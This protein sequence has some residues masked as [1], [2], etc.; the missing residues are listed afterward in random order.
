[1]NLEKGLTGLCNL[2]N[3]CF[4][5]TILQILSHSELLNNFLDTNYQSRLNNNNEAILLVE[6]DNL[7]KL[8]WKKNCIISPERFLKVIQNLAMKKQLL[9]FTDYSQNDVTEFIHFL[10]E[11]FH[12]GIT[13]EVNIKIE[14]ECKNE[15]DKIALLCYSTIKQMYEKDYSMIYK[16]FHGIFY[17]QLSNLETKDII[18]NIPEPFFILNLPI[19]EQKTVD[20]LDCFNLFTEEEYLID[21]NAYFNEKTN[22]KENISKKIFFWSLPD[23]LVIDLKRYN[24]FSRKNQKLVSFP[25]ENLD[26]SEYVV[27]YNKNSY[28]YD[29]YG[30]CNHSGETRGGH[31]YAYIK[32]ST[33]KWF[34]MN[35]TEIKEIKNTASL[36]TSKAYCF[37]YRKKT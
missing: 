29:L 18:K 3:T 36:I 23:I 26:L 21:E 12:L 37:F 34:K 14:G 15:N 7:R 31:Y 35:D 8:M 13:K 22:Q 19:P 10:L 5:N 4:M 17:S 28:K 6:W 27:G 30:I 20:L 11:S 33:N 32:T 25:L 9:L 16:L 1:M 2:G 24:N